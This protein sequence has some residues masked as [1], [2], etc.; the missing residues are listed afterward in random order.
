MKEEEAARYPE[1]G[2]EVPN[3]NSTEEG[4]GAMCVP[5]VARKEAQWHGALA[6]EGASRS[7]V[8]DR[9]HRCG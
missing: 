7:S 6:D 9:P 8:H 4:R 3:V 1:L 2:A 5:F